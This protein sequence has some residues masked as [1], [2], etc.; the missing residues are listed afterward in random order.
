VNDHMAERVQVMRVWERKHWR[1]LAVVTGGVVLFL[2]WLLAPRPGSPAV[3][4][5]SLDAI[6]SWMDRAEVV[7]LL[8]GPPGDY[9]RRTTTV[10]DAT[11]VVVP[12]G[13]RCDDEDL[14]LESPDQWLGEGM[15]I[16]VRFD[17]EG[18]VRSAFGVLPSPPIWYRTL[19]RWLPLPG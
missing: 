10:Y 2:A 4:P 7:R 16:V 1:R 3:G 19:R 18:K 6:R 13:L 17:E 14:S 12:N 15:L 9:R 8:G 5:A 11:A